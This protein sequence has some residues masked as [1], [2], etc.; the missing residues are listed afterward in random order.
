MKKRILICTL[1]ALSSG[2]FGG[3]IGVQATSILH[4]QK[5]Q[6]PSWGIQKMCNVWVTP[7]AI[8]QGSIAG[9]WTGT[10]LGAFVSGTLTRQSD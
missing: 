3:V 7:G 9:V 10:I 6:N 4:S 2:F 8:W 5:C 1:T